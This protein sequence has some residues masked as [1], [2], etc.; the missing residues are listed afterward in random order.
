MELR[1]CSLCGYT[2]AALDDT[3]QWEGTRYLD[4]NVISRALTTDPLLIKSLTGLRGE[5]KLRHS[6]AKSLVLLDI[7]ELCRIKP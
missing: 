4:V 6:T 7:D 5:M 2:E 1:A 3:R